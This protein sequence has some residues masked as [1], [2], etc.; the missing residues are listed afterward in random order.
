MSVHSAKVVGRM[1]ES[2]NLLQVNSLISEVEAKRA[3]TRLTKLAR[4]LGVGIAITSPSGERLF[5]QIRVHWE[6][7]NGH[8]CNRIYPRYFK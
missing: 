8:Q 4:G 1:F 7:S 2:I 5:R 6:S 3:M